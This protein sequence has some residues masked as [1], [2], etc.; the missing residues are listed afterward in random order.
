LNGDFSGEI[1]AVGNNVTSWKPGDKVFGCAGGAGEF[2]GALAE[3]ILVD[4]KFIAEKPLNIDFAEAALYPLVSITAWE[5]LREKVQ[6]KQGDKVLVHGAAGGVGH[7][8]LQLARLS[9]AE[10]YGT[11]HTQKQAEK[12]IELGVDTV[13]F[14]GKEPV[15][16]YVEK[17]TKGKGFDIVLDPV[18]G[19]NL[20]NSFKAVKHNGP[21]CTTN[22]R[23]TLDLGMMHAKAISLHAVFM[24]IPL[25]YGTGRERQGNILKSIS[26]MIENGQLHINR[27]ERQFTF[28]EISQAHSYFESG[29]A[30]GKISLINS[31]TGSV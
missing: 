3:F 10:V 21:V 15:E 26:S 14:A 17:Y 16:E 12:V 29:K 27:D 4:E 19:E 25:L 22:A 2:Q 8:A 5:A 30:M 23:V 28:N 9:G 13:I 18:G 1:T 24:L 11:V 20:L 6:I 7:I 31:F